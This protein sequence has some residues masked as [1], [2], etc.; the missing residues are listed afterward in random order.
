MLPGE[1]GVMTFIDCKSSS[2][3]GYPPLLAG[4]NRQK[5]AAVGVS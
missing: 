4:D 1:K 5:Q 2:A 3:D